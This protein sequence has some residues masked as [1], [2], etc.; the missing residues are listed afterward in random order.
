M[1]MQRM[2]PTI[3]EGQSK[4]TDL[5]NMS[6]LTIKQ[7]GSEG[8]KTITHQIEAA[9]AD[10]KNVNRSY[11]DAKKDLEK[12][13]EEWGTFLNIHNQLSSWIGEAEAQVKHRDQRSTL[14]EKTKELLTIKVIHL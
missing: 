13:L 2:Q 4:L 10:W 3:D 14:D 12:K 9:E 11:V 1:I 8:Q 6:N 5:H 7:T